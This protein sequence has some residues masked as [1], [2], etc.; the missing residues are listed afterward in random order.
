MSIHNVYADTCLYTH[1]IYIHIHTH[2]Y[3][4]YTHTNIS[5][6]IHI[7]YQR[8]APNKHRV[9]WQKVDDIGLSCWGISRPSFV[10]Q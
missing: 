6:C 3:I 10:G 8:L 2:V 7:E 9:P 1:N 5:M 4:Y